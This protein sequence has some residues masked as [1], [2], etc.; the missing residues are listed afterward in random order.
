M[1]LVAEVAA[2]QETFASVFW[3]LQIHVVIHAE[4]VMFNNPM[5]AGA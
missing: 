3:V 1:M 4:S 5:A 2:S